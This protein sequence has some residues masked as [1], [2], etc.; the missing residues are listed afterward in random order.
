HLSVKISALR[1][2]ALLGFGRLG[3]RLRLRHASIRAGR[4]RPAVISRADLATKLHAEML[5][6]WIPIA[7][8]RGR[9]DKHGLCHNQRCNPDRICVA[10][11]SVSSGG[12]GS[13]TCLLTM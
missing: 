8:T 10:F 5:P 3:D 1:G 2:L 12:T 7:T 4:R 11:T 9:P 13:T 6:D